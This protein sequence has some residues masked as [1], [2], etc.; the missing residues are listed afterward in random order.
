LYW[1]STTYANAPHGAW[2]VEFL[3]GGVVDNRF[4][5]YVKYSNCYARAV[6]GGL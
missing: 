6:R 4:F 1:S 3:H 2:S 5:D